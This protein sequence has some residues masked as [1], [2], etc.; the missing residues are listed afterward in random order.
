MVSQLHLAQFS[1]LTF[2]ECYSELCGVFG[3]SRNCI[4]FH[5]LISA[6]DT[7]TKREAAI[8]KICPPT[9]ITSPEVVIEEY[10]ANERNI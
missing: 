2:E 7:L 8:L 5:L 10:D 4:F 9:I 1:H 3:I 6:S